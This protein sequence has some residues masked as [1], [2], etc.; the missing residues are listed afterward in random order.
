MFEIEPDES[1]L[2][3][4]PRDQVQLLLH[5]ALGFIHLHAV[6]GDA[7]G[8]A[9]LADAVHELPIAVLQMSLS[10]WHITR[11]RERLARYELK[12]AVNPERGLVAMLDAIRIR[13]DAAPG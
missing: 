8:A 6:M 9:D 2:I 5:L 7:E 3:T 10:E 11:T 4:D 1:P 12:Y 13:M